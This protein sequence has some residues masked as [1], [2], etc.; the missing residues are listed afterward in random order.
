MSTSQKN[1]IRHAL[2]AA[3]SAHLTALREQ[4]PRVLDSDDDEHLHRFRVALRK[5]RALLKLFLPLV[6]DMRLLKDE[7]KWLAQVTG[8]TRDLDV[9]SMQALQRLESAPAKTAAAASILAELQHRRTAAREQLRELVDS[10]RSR[11]LLAQWQHFVAT[12]PARQNLPAAIDIPAWTAIEVPIL[13]NSRRLLKDGSAIDAATPAHAL[14]ELRIRGKR[15]RYL[16]ESFELGSKEKRIEPLRKKLLKLQTVLGEHQDGVVAMQHWQQLAKT[17]RR[18]KGIA[19]ATLALLEEWAAA[20][21]T[22][23]RE[24]RAGL[25]KALRQFARACGKL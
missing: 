17:L 16:L 6:P 8:E 7:L 1:T 13:K 3:W 20:E 23:Q 12:L 10:P 5:T 24:A 22:R 9:L 4:L 25:P 11:N 2:A 18:R 19:A 14:H 21:A 15:L